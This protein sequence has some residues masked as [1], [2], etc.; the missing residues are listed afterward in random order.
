MKI[1][2][3]TFCFIAGFALA[4]SSHAS[5]AACG[6]SSSIGRFSQSSLAANKTTT[7]KPQP[8]TGINDNQE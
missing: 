3:A 4:Q 8:K 1:L 7:A 2:F 6:A 5:Q